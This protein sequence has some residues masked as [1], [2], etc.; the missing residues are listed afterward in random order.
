MS[1]FTSFT[2]EELDVL[3]EVTNVGMGR[4]GVNLSQVFEERVTLNVPVAALMSPAD[5]RQ[6]FDSLAYPT[7]LNLV[8]QS[9]SGGIVGESFAV[10]TADAFRQIFDLMGYEEQDAE[11]KNR[12]REMLLDL[13][14]SL[15]SAELSGIA[16]LF[17]LSIELSKPAISG[18]MLQLRDS[19][20]LMDS[21]S[22]IG[23]MQGQILV[24]SVEF[25]IREKGFYCEN[26]FLI[27]NDCLADLQQRIQQ[28]L[29]K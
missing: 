15:N 14:N 2:A 16:E 12:Q 9:F 7:R 29:L 10:F 20:A 3:R 25:V 11:N 6:R 23:E 1:G 28:I 19:A 8:R 21:Q 13:T 5:L 22:W 26:I 4:A 24:L 27:R 18:F 17:D